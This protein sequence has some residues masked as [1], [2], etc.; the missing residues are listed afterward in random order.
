M[1][2]KEIDADFNSSNKEMQLVQPK[3]VLVQIHSAIV[4]SQLEQTLPEELAAH[5]S[6]LKEL[7]LL[8]AEKS[9][10]LTAVFQTT[11]ERMYRVSQKSGGKVNANI[12]H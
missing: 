5:S 4:N 10:T 8:G 2:N 12:S 9:S 7:I 3:A 6:E 11:L 1:Q